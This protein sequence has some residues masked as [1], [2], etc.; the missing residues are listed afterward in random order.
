[1]LKGIANQLR[2]YLKIRIRGYSPERFLNLC[3]NKGISIWGLE[4]KSGSYEMYITINGFRK[5]KPIVKKTRTRVEIVEKCGAPFFFYKYRKRK[6]FFGG[7]AFCIGLI[8]LLSLFVWNIEIEGNRAITDEVLIEYLE[9]ENVCHGMKIRD[10][11][12]ESIGTNIRK[13]FDDIIWVSVSLDGT[14]IIISVKENTDTSQVSVTEKVP[15]DIVASADGVIT[16]IIT[17]AGVPCVKAGDSVASGDMLVSGTVEVVNDAGE[18]VR[19]EYKAAEADIYAELIL[20][21]EE[22]CENKYDVKEYTKEKKIQVYFQIKDYW[23]GLGKIKFDSENYEV[24]TEEY[25]L[26]ID[27]NFELPISCG[28]KTGKRY[29]LVENDRSKEEKEAILNNKIA[30]YCKE[31]E[32]NGAVIL[33]KQIQMQE[34]EYATRATGYIKIEQAIGTVRKLVDF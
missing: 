25:R 21:Y 33:E 8:Y 17:R 2:G 23:C 26:K 13:N 7:M 24:S 28:I 12:C 15:C 31:L 3:K 4:A 22:V 9:T 19:E 29:E 32:E 34:E 20:P 10:V 18:V 1:M 11:D 30:L 14:N 6:V 5:L 16:E 27:E